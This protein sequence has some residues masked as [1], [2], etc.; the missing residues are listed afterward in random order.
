MAE[1]YQI[2][3]TE[4]VET[5]EKEVKALKEKLFQP[6]SHIQELI[7]EMD[8]LK[9]EIKQLKEIFKKALEATGEESS[10]NLEKL[11]EQNEKVAQAILAMNDKLERIEKSL[12][13]T[14]VKRE[15]SSLEEKK[16]L[17]SQAFK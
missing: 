12:G 8:G 7:I 16:R 9:E 5:L 2:Y 14:E 4:L 3:P 11:F 10:L 6:D 17:I 1:E 13:K 15:F